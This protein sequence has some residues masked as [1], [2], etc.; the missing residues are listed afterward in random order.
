MS[1][2]PTA[3]IESGAELGS[4]VTVGP[5]CYIATGT[6]VGDNTV[7]GPYVCVLQHTTIGPGCRIHAGATLGDLPQD[8]SFKDVV[9]H[10][11]IGANCTIREGV[12]VHRGT[13]PDTTTE[14]GDECYLMCNSHFAHNVKLGKSVIVANGAACAGYV[15]VGDRAFISGYCAIHQFVRIGRLAMVGALTMAS[16]DIPPFFTTRSSSLNGVAGCN[17]VG[18]RRAGMSAEDRTQVRKAFSMLYRSNLNVSQAVEALR[19]TFNAGP[20]VEICDFIK[21]SKRGIAR[22]GERESVDRESVSDLPEVFGP[23]AIGE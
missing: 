18:M 8:L 15:E 21:Q 5:Y 11:R 16:K 3:I 23:P 7:M 22:A 2:H 10:T 14:I 9:S 12:T 17:I 19:A 1:I 4:N 20:V 6:V 13:K